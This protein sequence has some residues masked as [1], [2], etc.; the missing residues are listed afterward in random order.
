MKKNF[1]F[2]LL[3][4]TTASL[5][6][7]T[8]PFAVHFAHG[9]EIFPENIDAYRAGDL[10]LP[11]ADGLG[12]CVFY[13]Q[14]ARI[15]SAE[16]RARLT[17]E[18]GVEWLGYVD[19]GAYLVKTPATLDPESLAGLPLRGLA[20]V[21]PAWKLARS[22]REPPYGVWAVHGDWLDVQLQVYP[23]IPIP[24]G[25]ALC[26]QNGIRVVFE[27]AQ[28]G[29]LK[30]QIRQD[31]LDSVAALPFVQYLELAPPPPVPDDARGRSLHRA[32]LLDAPGAA[33]LHYDGTGVGV[34]VRDDGLL[35][36]H[37]DF[38]GRLHNLT[39]EN[40]NVHHGDGVGGIIAGAGNL[41]PT[42]RGMAAGAE[43]FVIDYTAEFQDQTLPLHLNQNVTLTNSSYSEQCNEGYT[44]NSQTVDLQLFEN[45]TLMH[46][47]SAGNRGQDN[48]GYGA[49]TAWGTITGGHKAA[50]NAI[51]TANLRAD[52]TLD[53]TSS[54][55]P[56][57]DG[58][59]KP[60]ISAN[61]TEQASTDSENAYQVFGG[62]SAAS[63]G[64][65]GCLAQL[66]QYWKENHGGQ[67]PY[68]ALLK[69]A[70]LN[71]ANDLGNPGPDY[72]FGWGHVNNWRAYRL[73]EEF[74]YDAGF[75]DQAGESTHTISI[76]AGV[77]QARVM[78]YWTDPPALPGTA[79]ALVNDLDLQ[80][81]A[82]DGSVFLPLVL[83][84]TPNPFI[85]NTPATPGR[86]SLNNVEQVRLD[87]PPAGDFLI[88]I[89]GYE[90]PFGP[91]AYFLVRE[92]LTDEIKIT[93]PAGGEGIVPGQ[94]E[95]IH[96]DAFGATPGEDF[97][98]EWFDGQNW[99]TLAQPAYYERF[100]DWAVPSGIATGQARLR[101]T[102]GGAT[103]ETGPFTIVRL[104]ANVDIVRVCPD[105]LTL[106][107]T[108]VNDTL[109]YEVYALGD[110]YMEIAGAT[111]TTIF[112]LPIQNAVADQWLSVRATGPGGLTGRRALAVHW[113]GELKECPQPDDL[114]VR[115]LAAPD[116]AG[117]LS[118][119]P[120]QQSVSVEVR[121]E[122]LNPI[123]GAMLNLEV[124]GQPP[125]VEALPTLAAGQSLTHTFQTLLDLTTNDSL[126]LQIWAIF[127]DDDFKP[128]DTLRYAV[129]VVT[130][131][132]A[133]YFTVGFDTMPFLPLGWSVLNPDNALTWQRSGILTLP[134]GQETRT[135]LLECYN[136]SAAGQEDGIQMIPVDLSALAAPALQFDLAHA[137]FN[138]GV[139][140][141]RVDVFPGCDLS[142]APVMVWEKSDPALSTAPP[143][144]SYFFP[145]EDSDW[146]TEIV[147]LAAFAGQSVI[148]R[149]TAT[150]GYGNN[151]FLDNVGIVQYGLDA[152]VAVIVAPADSICRGDTVVFTALP[153]GNLVEYNWLFGSLAQPNSAF[154]QGPHTVYYPTPGLK[155]VR[156]IAANPLGADTATHLLTVLNFPTADFTVSTDGLE[157]TFTNTSQ[158]ALDYLWDF[159]DGAISAETSPVHAYAGGGSYWVKLIAVNPCKVATDSLLLALSVGA[160]DLENLENV[161]V[162]PNPTGGDFRVEIRSATGGAVRL[163]LFD[164]LGREVTAPEVAVSPGLTSVPFSGLDLPAGV[165]QLRLSNRSGFRILKVIVH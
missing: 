10:A 28:N 75:C 4:L 138:N 126:F 101:L 146:R 84:P 52:A 1:A 8:N 31:Q 154:G 67:N 69:A 57:A 102:R 139:E 90:V 32:N 121:N 82:P 43:V 86:D 112:T 118:C 143:T 37:I 56:T 93:S 150:N 20:P 123:D 151:I 72:R 24:Q 98:L 19:F 120:V 99:S 125:L 63:P 60:D 39:I 58:R 71:T 9:A 103:D 18:A 54:R 13:L 45:G 34:L 157:A 159:G 137:Q 50:K 142:A 89:Q 136:Y 48:C 108:A 14:C 94:V 110:R 107:W 23:H 147:D 100:Y 62:T 73:L 85:L 130:Q 70:L 164:A 114:G 158:N 77:R 105:S 144:N 124:N 12:H 91:Q 155:L 38:Q 134:D 47:F 92:F 26:R 17:A 7:Q 5:G 131:P 41:D 145:D 81:V 44:L 46:V 117:L 78:L 27:G 25:A 111:D 35:G 36:P 66:T 65:A 127:P 16:E 53:A 80:V 156:L 96:W 74:R 165:Y 161:R 122:G 113:P 129:P 22:L 135:L 132:A 116:P 33:G 29:F 88:K 119:G 79:K 95:R 15:L 6:A 83:N 152:P 51:A 11:G 109:S 40:G 68:T 55:G 30:V 104:P 87:N 49:G 21:Q 61:G 163:T 115:V 2:L 133:T 76:P 149:I 141:L 59:L 64:I 162:V 97:L 153:G 148:L 3:L 106:A 42:K 128:N 160:E 140:R